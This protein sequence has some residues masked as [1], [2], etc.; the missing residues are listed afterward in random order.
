MF[1]ILKAGYLKKG[2]VT[3]KYPA[4]PFRAPEKFL[5]MPAID[6]SKCD[7][8]GKCLA[9]CPSGAI[10]D[11]FDISPGRCIFCAAC[12]DVCSA[13][14]M[15]GEYELASKAKP[16]FDVESSGRE[17]EKKIKKA[18]GRSLAIR[19]VD[20]GSCNGC[21]VEVNSLSN[22]IYDI[23][24]FGLHIV[25]SPRHADALLV[26]GPVTRNM[27]RGLMQS[28]NATPDPKMVIA[29][30]ACAITGGI[31]RDSYAVYNGVDALVPV[32]V[33]IPG[34]PPRPQAIIQGIM[35]AIDR[36][37]EKRK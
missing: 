35:L 1:D 5:G 10:N 23:E 6:K 25:A 20:A 12:A 18:F 36:W 15:T 24:R 13:I 11:N 8:C 30:G 29:M 21:E 33:Y 22:A 28:Y 31:F 2:V 14:R 26:T 37:E 17:L 19:E 4:E 16:D 34:C 7:R 9:A 27:E 3:S 32:D